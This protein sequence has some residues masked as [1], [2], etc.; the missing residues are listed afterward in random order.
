MNATKLRSLTLLL[1][2]ALVAVS[3]G[4]DGGAP[5]VQRMGEDGVEVVFTERPR[6]GEMEGWRLSDS[7]EL[8]IGEDTDDPNYLFSSIISPRGVEAGYI[9]GAGYIRGPFRLPDGQIAVGDLRSTEVRFFD[10]SGQFVRAAVGEGGGPTELTLLSELHHCVPGMLAAIDH[11]RDLLAILDGDGKF[12]GRFFFEDNADRNLYPPIT[13]NRNGQ[14]LAMDWGEAEARLQDEEFV[15]YRTRVHMWLLDSEGYVIRDLGEFPGVERFDYQGPTG[16]VNR[17]SHPLGKTPGRALGTDRAFIGTADD[18]EIQVWSLDGV[19]R[20]RWRRPV[21]DSTFLEE[22]IAAYAALD[23][24]LARLLQAIRR[25]FPTFP[26]PE[27]YPAYTRFILDATDHL[28]VEHFR[29]PRD[30]RHLW[31]V[32][33]PNGVWL[34]EVEVPPSFEITEVGEDYVLGVYRDELDEQSVRMYGLVRD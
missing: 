17:E 32:F 8:V 10:T 4:D 6:W 1:W 5:A 3:V 30:R 28:W 22:D 29:T 31:S 33:A 12:H 15:F 23:A 27:T 16:G 26:M 19:L 25:R 9:V 34:G 11:R 14:I 24:D 2:W 20:Q 18:F 7:P 13:C 21:G